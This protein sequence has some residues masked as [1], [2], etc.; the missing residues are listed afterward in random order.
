MY[1]IVDQLFHKA[2]LSFRRFC[3]EIDNLPVDLHIIM[4][5]IIN[6]AGM[7]SWKPIYYIK[8]I[9][10]SLCMLLYTNVYWGFE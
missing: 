5:D 2:F 4:S 6:G 9:I 7:L 3:C 8:G 1:V 10:K